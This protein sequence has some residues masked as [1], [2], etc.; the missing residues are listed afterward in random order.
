M[1]TSF[2]ELRYKIIGNIPWS[3]GVTGKY[4]AKKSDYF[5]KQV[6]IIEFETNSGEWLVMRKDYGDIRMYETEAGVKAAIRGLLRNDKEAKRAKAEA[7]E[8][9]TT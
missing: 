6:F 4:R 1:A 2:D 7:G 9:I 3:G 8:I 5:G